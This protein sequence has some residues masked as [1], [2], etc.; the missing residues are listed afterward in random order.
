MADLTA[1]VNVGMSDLSQFSYQ[2]E[3]LM[4]FSLRLQQLL[5]NIPGNLNCFCN[6]SSLHYQTRYIIA[7]S[8]INAFWQFFYM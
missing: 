5:G 7:C 2:L 1:W 6:R 3:M 8:E 4:P